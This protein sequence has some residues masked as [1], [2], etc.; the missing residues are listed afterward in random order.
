MALQRKQRVQ[1]LMR[2]FCQ[3]CFMLFDILVIVRIEIYFGWKTQ[4]LWAK[5]DSHRQVVHI[6]T[7]ILH[8]ELCFSS[9]KPKDSYRKSESIGECV[10][11]KVCMCGISHY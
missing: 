2:R 7:M 1:Q 8:V 9:E 3:E 11:N 6:A 10:C 4:S 5:S